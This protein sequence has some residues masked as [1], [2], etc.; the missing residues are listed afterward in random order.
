MAR[1]FALLVGINAYPPGVRSLTGCV[2]DVGRYEAWLRRTFPTNL[3]LEKLIDSDATRGNVITQF[4]KH[5][6]QAEKG[7]VALFQYAG[8]GARSTAAPEFI[9]LEPSGKEEGLVC[10]NSRLPGNF[11]LADKE[12]AVLIAQVA[13]KHPHIAVILDSCHSGSGTR[14]A[15][16]IVGAVARFEEPVPYKREIGQY[17][18]DVPA[19]LVGDAADYYLQ[20][21]KAGRI[22]IPMGDHML[23][24][25]CGR[26]QTAKEFR[27]SGI[28]SSTVMEVLEQSGGGIS[29]ADLFVR[30]RAAVRTRAAEQ[31]PQFDTV[32]L[33][34]ARAGFLGNDTLRSSLPYRVFFEAN[35]WKVDFGAI[36]GAPTDPAKTVSFAVYPDG[37]GVDAEPLGRATT[38]WVG[39]HESELALDFAAA[40]EVTAFSA[41]MTSL[42][43]APMLFGYAGDDRLRA[44]LLAAIAGDVSAG[45]GL[46][47]AAAGSDYIIAP[48]GDVVWIAHAET[49]RQIQGVRIDP[50][51]PDGDAQLL[52]SMMKTIAGWHRA[53][54]LQNEATKLDV[55]K[56]DLVYAEEMPDGSVREHPPGEI[57]L[58]YRKV[59][60]EWQK[61]RG[62]LKIRNRSDQTLYIAMFYCPTDYRIRHLPTDA[63]GVA[64]VSAPGGGWLTLIGASANETFSLKDGVDSSVESFKLIISTE[65][66]DGFLLSQAGLEI[67][68]IVGSTRN[69]DAVDPPAAAKVPLRNEWFTL[70]AGMKIVRR[71]DVVGAADAVLGGGAVTVLA[72][73]QVTADLALSPAVSTTRSV[74]DPDFHRAFA[75]LGMPMVDFAA[76]TRG[77]SV[78]VLEL[79][80]I[81]NSDALETAP[82]QIALKVPLGEEETLVPLAFDG[83]F[84]RLGGAAEK[85]ADGSVLVSI[86]RVPEPAADSRS[87]LGSLKLYF[88]KTALKRPTVDM[89]RWADFT[90]EGGDPRREFGIRDKVAAAK[91]IL[92]LVHGIIGDTEAMATDI[93]AAGIADKFDLVLTYDYENLD[94]PIGDTAAALEK[95]LKGVG[96]G[97]GDD[98]KLT[99]LA[100]S[101]GGLVSRWCIEQG[102]GKAFVDHLVMCGTPNSGS[103][104]GR[105]G[106][107]MAVVRMLGDLSANLLPAALPFVA[108]LQTVLKAAGGVTK[109]LEQMDPASTFFLDLNASDD[110]KLRYSILAGNVANYAASEEPFA[111]RL[112]A[113]TG[114][115]AAFDLLFEKQPHDIAVSVESIGGV[116]GVRAEQPLRIDVACH[117]LNYF[118]SAPGRAALQRVDWS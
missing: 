111:G 54:A 73:P 13:K 35:R 53:M 117:H 48:D 58:E 59:G 31:E 42:P 41:E 83:E 97:A 88:F 2:N 26:R 27:G 81:A 51:A 112:L 15:E 104:L 102:G 43:V 79:S 99:I 68:K 44:A 16:E 101:M 24:A 47:D 9:E 100:H 82:L 20:L 25:A 39:A 103:P 14:S 5:L 52:F 36:Q 40:S 57:R 92:L 78:N 60:D 72:H 33:F 45:V 106:G 3:A 34:N 98:K 110:P 77:G 90:A 7:D 8:H 28:F 94:T 6:G 29:Y 49:G 19:D 38:T 55:S 80:N 12:L 89:L 115:S 11:D 114:R 37:A 70:T 17:L 22:A 65:K 93:K 95:R 46:A 10:Y 105:I 86:D 66:F 63:L 71:Q 61:I 76:G 113:D 85:R 32:G 23:M 87:L 74:G 18:S 84:V 109:T 4:I 30:C 1:V 118:S 64:D 69:F 91:N 96:I 50:A 75:R 108:P 62:R 116:G 56:I 21:A 107:A 67:G